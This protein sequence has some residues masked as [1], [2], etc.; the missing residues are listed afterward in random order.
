MTSFKKKELI[1]H[2]MIIKKLIVPI[3]LIRLMSIKILNLHLTLQNV[4]FMIRQFLL[5]IDYLKTT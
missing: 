4:I 3:L 5:I 1:Y 2:F